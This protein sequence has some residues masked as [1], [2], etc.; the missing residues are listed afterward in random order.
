MIDKIPGTP[1]K[2]PFKSTPR[3][4]GSRSE[5]TVALGEVIGVQLRAIYDEVVAQ[6]IPDRLL[7]LLSRI[8]DKADDK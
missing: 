8:D 7:E 5:T 6:P 2:D 4:A 3:S 1:R